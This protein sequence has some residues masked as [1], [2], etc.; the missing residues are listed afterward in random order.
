MKLKDLLKAK[1][2]VGWQGQASEPSPVLVGAIVALVV[3]GAY[4]ALV[5]FGGHK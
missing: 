3:A 1:R 5:M 4:V 2:P